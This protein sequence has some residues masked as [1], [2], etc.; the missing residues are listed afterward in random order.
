LAID[1]FSSFYYL[2]DE[3]TVSNQN[4][5]FDEG[6]GE[7]LAQIS[8]GQYTPTELVLAI[9]TALEAASTL[10]QEYTVSFNRTTRKLTISAA[11]NFDL[12]ISSGS[13]VGTSPWVLLGFT[14]GAD[15]T[16]TN[17][18]T[19]QSELGSIYTPQFKLQDYVAPGF[20]KEQIDPSV[21][22]SA[23]GKL[24]VLNFGTRSFIE[25]RIP[26][27]TNE[28]AL[29]DCRYILPDASGVQNTLTFLEF[30]ITKSACEFN[31]DKDTPGNFE[32]VIL[33]RTSASGSGTGFKLRER[34]RDNIRD[35]YDTG[36]L[37][38][39]LKE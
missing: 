21:N 1:T 16:A 24:E 35:V 23:S 10:P 15:L 17:T 8:V 18:Y 9:K 13:Q 4:L 31:P 19:G 32:T 11:A 26:F 7:L 36:L 30:L 27:V 2:S 34:V 12:L 29:A 25:M 38:F 6:G 3:I 20:N 37:R 14:G 22:E 5:N 39:R 33:E 28:L